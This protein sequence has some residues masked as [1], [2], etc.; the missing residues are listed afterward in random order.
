MGRRVRVRKSDRRGVGGVG[1]SLYTMNE[2]SEVKRV[3][4][5]YSGAWEKNFKRFG[6]G[7][8]LQV[9]CLPYPDYNLNNL[10]AGQW[11]NV[12]CDMNFVYTNCTIV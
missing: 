11:G 5:Q 9:Y 8:G 10:N 1:G 4:T 6:V 2:W 3:M 7:P 12:V